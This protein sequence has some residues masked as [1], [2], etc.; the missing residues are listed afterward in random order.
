MAEKCNHLP[1]DAVS[2]VQEISLDHQRSL[3]PL[4]NLRGFRGDID[5]VILEIAVSDL[6]LESLDVSNNN[7]LPLECLKLLGSKMKSLRVLKCSKLGV[8]RDIE[9]VAIAESMPWLEELDISYPGMD[10]DRDGLS[11]ISTASMP[12]GLRKIDISGNHFLTDKSLLALSSNCAFLKEIV[13]LHCS[14]VT[15]HDIEFVMR[16]SSQLSL[17]SVGKIEISRSSL[18]YLPILDS[19]TSARGLSTLYIHNSLVPDE[20]SL[21]ACKSWVSFKEVLSISLLEFH[22]LWSDEIP[23]KV[24]FEQRDREN[25]FKRNPAFASE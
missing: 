1:D 20:F 3:N 2:R 15:P 17:I 16:N 12:G 10:L 4:R 7:C 9:L 22:L 21:F 5:R 18:Y 24:K 23:E 14:L 6:K 25:L 11:Y 19:F 8:F 13:I